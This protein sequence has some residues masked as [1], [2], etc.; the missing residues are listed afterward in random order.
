MHLKSMPLNILS[1]LMKVLLRAQ[2]GH[3]VELMSSCL[4]SGVWCLVLSQW[5]LDNLLAEL[6]R[7]MRLWFCASSWLSSS[8]SSLL[9]SPFICKGRKWFIY[10]LPYMAFPKYVYVWVYFWTH[11]LHQAWVLRPCAGWAMPRTRA[12]A[13]GSPACRWRNNIQKMAETL[14][15]DKPRYSGS[16]CNTA[17]FNTLITKLTSFRFLQVLFLTRKGRWWAWWP[18]RPPWRGWRWH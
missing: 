8:S 6:S 3:E 7:C 5:P 9:S 16:T 11:S 15:E 12:A 18:W 14:P 13:A 2:H 17:H 1:R 10:I 4:V